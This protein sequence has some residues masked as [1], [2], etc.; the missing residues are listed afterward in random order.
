[1]EAKLNIAIG[2]LI[3]NQQSKEYARGTAK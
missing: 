3:I 2:I 1:M